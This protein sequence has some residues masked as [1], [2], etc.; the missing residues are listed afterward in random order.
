M[1]PASKLTAASPARL[2]PLGR[3][4]SLAG[5]VIGLLGLAGRR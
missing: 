4:L 2:T 1:T 5:G 3:R